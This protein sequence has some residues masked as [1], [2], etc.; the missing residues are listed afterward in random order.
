MEAILVSLLVMLAVATVAP[1]LASLVPGRAVPE[2]VF[3]VFVGAIL[4]PHGLG[5]FST[6]STAVKLISDLGMGFVFLMAGYEINLRDLLSPSGRWAVGSWLVSLALGTLVVMA[7]FS[8]LG[9]GPASWVALAILLTTTAYGTLAPILHDRDL[10]GTPVGRIVTIHG[11]LGELLPIFAMA[12]LFSTKS[13][14][15]TLA[16]IILFLLVVLAVLL[17]S[18][19]FKAAGTGFWRFLEEKSETASFPLVRMVVTILVLLLV[20]STMGGFDGVL[21]AFAAGFILRAL[22]PQGNEGLERNLRV[23]GGGFFQPLFF[24]VSGAGIDLAAATSNLRLLFGFILALA[25]VRGLVVGLTLNLDA[26]TKGL[27]WQEKF[28]AAAYCTMAL[29][30]VVAITSVAQTQGVMTSQTASVLVT[31]AALTVLLIPVVTSL[32]R[33]ADAAEAVE[34]VHELATRS[35]SDLSVHDILHAHHL[36]FN[37][38]QEEFRRQI[39]LAHERGE[40]L[41]A[42]EFMA[43]GGHRQ[44]DDL[45]A[46]RTAWERRLDD[47]LRHHA[48]LTSQDRPER[49]AGHVRADTRRQGQD[50]PRPRR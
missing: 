14:R 43:H 11:A 23:L 47:Y 36:A 17:F 21:G 28:S 12:I 8:R 39:I 29:P 13:L 33:V 22:F 38:H 34:A 35:A 10:D 2:V 32:V 1:F 44:K 26:S 9:L 25:L 42:A 45:D 18:T 16:S 49:E 30:L 40:Q 15:G 4:G 19:R 5:L 46:I 20:A 48:P 3:L 6:D 41:S 50:R 24:V 7:F 27:S 37:Q 31:S